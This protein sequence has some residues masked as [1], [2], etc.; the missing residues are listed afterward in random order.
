MKKND[1]QK[2]ETKIPVEIIEQ[3]ILDIAKGMRTLEAT[4]LNRRAIV[5]LLHDHTRVPKNVIE[6]ILD[7]MSSL[8]IT[9]CKKVRS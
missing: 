6:N 4:R 9:Y 3:G 5:A 1:A 7:S 8:E 2:T